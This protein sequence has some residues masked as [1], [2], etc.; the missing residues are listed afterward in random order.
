M[1]KKGTTKIAG[2]TARITKAT[3]VIVFPPLKSPIMNLAIS[4]AKKN[5]K[6]ND[7]PANIN[8]IFF[9]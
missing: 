5:N 6:R 2:D 1:L 9:T 4:S 3:S 8:M 7:R